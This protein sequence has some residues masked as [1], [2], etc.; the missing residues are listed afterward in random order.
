M[1]H[2]G[3]SRRANV[4]RD[5]IIERVRACVAESLAVEPSEVAPGSRLIGDLGAD[6]L[7]F[8]DIVFG[9]ESAFGI[10]L[11][12]PSLDMVTRAEAS[13]GAGASLSPEDFERAAEWLPALRDAPDRA[14]VTARGLIAYVTIESL[15]LMV[16]RKLATSA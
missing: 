4:D 9:L 12:D 2:D 6:S 13:D 5:E 1:F 3:D 14:R 11:R 10:K 8:L 7:D 15:A 16:E